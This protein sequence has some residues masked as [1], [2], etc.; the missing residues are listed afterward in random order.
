[1]SNKNF[2]QLFDRFSKNVREN[3]ILTKKTTVMLHL[4][5]TMAIGCNQ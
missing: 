4:A 2:D 3:D 1:M 5:V